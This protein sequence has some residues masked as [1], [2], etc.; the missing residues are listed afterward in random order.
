[1]SDLL[2]RIKAHA[3]PDRVRR[4]PVPEWAPEGGTALILTYR[5]VTLDD[6]SLVQEMDG[7]AW[8]KRAARIIALKACDE[9]GQRLFAVGDAVALRQTADPGVIS[10]IALQ[11]L[12]R[13]SI[14]D[15]EK[16]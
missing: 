8:H 7:D 13:T 1:M 15:A 5:M 12:G 6:L 11:M 9:N 14:E 10:R 2:D 16:N 4:L 3:E